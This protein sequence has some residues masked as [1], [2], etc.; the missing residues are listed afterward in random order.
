MD[1]TKLVITYG[2]KWVGNFYEG[3]E[4]ELKKVHRN[5]TY[6]ELTRLVQGVANVDVTRFTI[7][8][9]T[10]VD[11]GVRLRPARPKI[12]DDSDVEMLL[13]DDGHV[14][15]VYVSVVEKV[16]IV[17]GHVGDHTDQP[18]YQSFLQQL[19]AQFQSA[20]GSNN[21]MGSIPTTPSVNHVISEGPTINEVMPEPCDED[22]RSIPDYNPHTEYGLDDF[23]EDYIGHG[24]SREGVNDEPGHYDGMDSDPSEGGRS[25]SFPPVFGGPNP[26]TCEDDAIN[27][28]HRSETAVSQPWIIPGASNNSFEVVRT[29]ESSSCNRLSKGG[30]FQSKKGVKLALQSYALKENFEIRVTRSSQVRYEVGCKDPECKFHFRAAKMVEGGNYW[31][32]RKFEEEHSCTI[33]ELHNRNRQAS[34]WLIGEILAPKLAVTG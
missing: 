25:R 10:L 33:D 11:T 28:G 18:V 17:S 14:P 24:G 29:E 21:V 5:L 34:S 32:V 12:K 20:G 1:R 26:D 7:E 16:S 3:G 30:L 9:R 19:A 15:E 13:C 6:A 2:G 27:V 31:I 23:D 22:D 8:L 4:T